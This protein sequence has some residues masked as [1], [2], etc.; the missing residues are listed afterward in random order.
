MK[1]N[2]PERKKKMYHMLSQWEKSDLNQKEF[3]QKNDVN[4]SVLKYWNKK[5]KLEHEIKDASK[6][7]HH[8]SSPPKN[9]DKF[10]PITI[11]QKLKSS[12]LRIT[13][14]N[15]VQLYCPEEIELEQFKKLIQIY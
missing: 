3:C 15:G 8:L 10:I 4:Y 11:T 13:Y 1:R 12:G 2:D 5:R 6:K 7:G 9:T 14:P